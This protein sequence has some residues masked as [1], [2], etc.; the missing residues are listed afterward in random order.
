MIIETKFS[1]GQVVWKIHRTYSNTMAECRLC[2]FSD[3]VT[4][5]SGEKIP[6]PER[7]ERKKIDKWSP[8]VVERTLTIRNVRVSLYDDGFPPYKADS[9]ERIYMTEET[10]VGSGSLHHEKDLFATKEAAEAECYRRNTDDPT[11]RPSIP[12]KVTR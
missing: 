2:G 11:A 7:L 10:G 6:C 4:L 3:Q 8:W 1:L 9:N 5:T 12:S